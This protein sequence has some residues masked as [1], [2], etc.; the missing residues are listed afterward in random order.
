MSVKTSYEII[1]E[2]VSESNDVEE[3]ITETISDYI[4]TEVIPMEEVEELLCFKKNY[5]LYYSTYICIIN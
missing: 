1:E 3:Q 2:N 5:V 4:D